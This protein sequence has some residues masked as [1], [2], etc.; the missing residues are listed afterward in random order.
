MKIKKNDQVIVLSGADKGK[1]GKVLAVY[2]KTGRVLVEGINFI[3][4]HQRQTSANGPSG[5]I[6]KEAAINA[7]SVALVQ[8]GKAV[9][10][11]YK[12]LDDGRKVRYLKDSGEIIDR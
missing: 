10:V 9:K 11:G 5:I 4:K 7:S 1:T 3:K 6:E 2:P 12:F 8:D